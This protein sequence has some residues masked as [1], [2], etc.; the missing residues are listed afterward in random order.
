MNYGKGMSLVIQ[1]N[2]ESDHGGL[3]RI[4]DLARKIGET[5]HFDRVFTLSMCATKDEGKVGVMHISQHYPKPTTDPGL[6]EVC[7]N[8]STGMSEV[9]LRSDV[10]EIA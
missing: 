1:P 7:F 6:S 4:S 8:F 10:I 2:K 9:T 5:S 3:V